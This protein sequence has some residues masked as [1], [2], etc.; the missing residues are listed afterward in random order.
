MMDNFEP[1]VDLR[2]LKHVVVFVICV[3]VSVL[4]YP[5]S[6][7]EVVS[8]FSL[9]EAMAK[10]CPG[11]TIYVPAG[12]TEEISSSVVGVKLSGCRFGEHTGSA[13]NIE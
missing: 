4:L 2:W 10:A 11:D 3:C 13:I 8:D 7:D 5:A 6:V 9:S 1:I 12:H